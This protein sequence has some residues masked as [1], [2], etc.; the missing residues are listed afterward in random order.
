MVWRSTPN[1]F[2]SAAELIVEVRIM[3]TI[4]AVEF[5]VVA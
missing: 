1:C 4:F 5:F 2:A 3:R